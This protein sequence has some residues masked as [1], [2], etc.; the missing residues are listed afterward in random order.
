MISKYTSVSKMKEVF[1][2][3]KLIIFKI[4]YNYPYK[5]GWA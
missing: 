2:I 5:E 3:L 4:W 1:C